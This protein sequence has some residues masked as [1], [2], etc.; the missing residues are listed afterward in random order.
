MRPTHQADQQPGDDRAPEAADAAEHDDQER[1]HHRVDAHVRPDAPDRRQ[2]DAGERREHGA[3][4]EH[5]RAAAA[6]G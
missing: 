2:D 1:R 5:A 3:E 6:T 4:R